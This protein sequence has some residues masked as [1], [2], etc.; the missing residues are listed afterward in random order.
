MFHFEFLKLLR[1]EILL[2]E[3]KH[4]IVDFKENTFSLTY[5]NNSYS[6]KMIHCNF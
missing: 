4:C 3:D 6:N 2:H 5:K 1:K